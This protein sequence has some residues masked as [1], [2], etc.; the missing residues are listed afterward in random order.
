MR[1]RARNTAT[2]S[3]TSVSESVT[4]EKTQRKRPWKHSRTIGLTAA[5]AVVIGL[6]PAGPGVQPA[7]AQETSFAV[8]LMKSMAE[9]AGG[10]AVDDLFGWVLG[11]GGSTDQNLVVL[12]EI[13]DELDTIEDTLV[14]I[15]NEIAAELNAIEQ[16]DCD[17]WVQSAEKP[18]NAISNLWDPNSVSAGGPGAPPPQQSYVGINAE[19]KN[20]TVTVADM[21]A[22]VD[23]VLNNNGQGIGGLSIQDHLQDLA[24]LLI[25]PAGGTGIIQSCL[26]VASNGPS[27]YKGKTDDVYYHDVVAPLIGYYY[28]IQTQGM[29]M[30]VEALNFEAW[31]TAGSPISTSSTIEDL[32]TVICGDPSGQVAQYCENADWVVLGTNGTSGVRGRVAAQ[33]TLGGAA[34]SA[35]LELGY[36]PVHRYVSSTDLWASSPELFTT[37]NSPSCAGLNSNA[38]CGIL[39][40]VYSNTT[41]G[42]TYGFYGAGSSSGGVWKAA[43][44]PQ[45]LEIFS[46]GPNFGTAYTNVGDYLMKMRGFVDLPANTI[47]ITNQTFKSYPY[48][49]HS[50]WNVVL[51]FTDTGLVSGQFPPLFNPDFTNNYIN[52]NHSLQLYTHSDGDGCQYF[53]KNPKLPANNQNKSFHAATSK[54]CPERGGIGGWWLSGPPGWVTDNGVANNHPQFRLPVLDVT[55]LKCSAGLHATNPGGAYRMCGD[56]FYSW[57][58][59]QVPPA[60]PTGVATGE[61]G[62]AQTKVWPKWDTLF[63]KGTVDDIDTSNGVKIRVTDE[64]NLFETRSIEAKKCRT[65]HWSGRITCS[66]YGHGSTLWLTLRP[67]KH[68]DGYKFSLFLR[69]VDSTETFRGPVT[70]RLTE[71]EG[72]AHE[73]TAYDCKTSHWGKYTC[74]AGEA[75]PNGGRDP[76]DP[77]EGDPPVFVPDPDLLLPPMDDPTPPSP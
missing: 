23:Q 31:Q 21:E 18:V 72:P 73:G 65:H 28:A 52:T 39:K 71:A 58:D 61:V 9:E 68:S 70:L 77:N 44:G 13:L 56:D 22:W 20:N 15:E 76:V 48:T 1:R 33:L 42:G 62:L 40:G 5:L 74:K 36:Q 3:D 14:G 69:G 27:N 60:T 2:R 51:T 12:N 38:P 63:A 64:T 11:S 19:T 46:S 67:L 32:P 59:T 66:V 6:L 75:P 30:V 49:D 35:P 26:A 7:V 50:V 47:F 41:V 54:F 57:L 16:L 43:S 4:T 8:D 24:Q 17:T 10:D 25:P 37:T 34:Y 45:L 29:T 55:S 53:D